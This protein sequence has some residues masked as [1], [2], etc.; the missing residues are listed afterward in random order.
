VLVADDDR[1]MR[2]LIAATLRP[3][4]YLIELVEDGQQAVERVGKG[5]I[6]L[7][8]LDIM[9]PRL[10]GLDACR[11]IKSLTAEAFLPV[12]LC[13]VRTDSQSRVEGLKLGAD[14]YVSKPFDE[15]ELL[16]R[17]ASMLRIKRL[18]DHVIEAR[19]RL[20][21]VSVFDE[22]TG[23]Y[24]YRHLN[25]RLSEEFKRAERQQDPLS[26]ALVDIDGLQAINSRHGQTAG[27]TVIRGVADA[28]RSSVREPDVVARFGG[29][30]FLLILPNTHFAGAVAV[31]ERIL[32]EARA[33]RSGPWCTLS[34]GIA[35][36][37]SRDVRT[38]DALLRAADAAL[39]QAKQEGGRRV[40][41]FQ[42]QGYIHAPVIEPLPDGG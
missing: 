31:S 25:L 1:R 10:S 12:V 20:E 5:G 2:E 32:S 29:D 7:V 6:D 8:L 41:V 30:E 34:V 33:R 9:M 39:F 37:P 23:V 22:L 35:L 16:T 14:D 13:T 26:C 38:K 17:V 36:Y 18:H 28:I 21:R 19:R 3:Q 42:Q 27:D 24:N 4:G 11:L 40:C 15:T